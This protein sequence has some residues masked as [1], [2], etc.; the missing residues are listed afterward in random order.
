[1]GDE[2]PKPPITPVHNPGRP[3]DSLREDSPPVSE[4]LSPPPRSGVRASHSQGA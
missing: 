1:M 4:K 2:K 3:V